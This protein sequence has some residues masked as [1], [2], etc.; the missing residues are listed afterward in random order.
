MHSATC[1]AVVLTRLVCADGPDGYGV[2]TESARLAT[3][4]AFCDSLK[5][6]TL[7]AT[8][9][10]PAGGGGGGGGGGWGG[11]GGGGDGGAGGGGGRGGG[12]RTGAV[13]SGGQGTGRRTRLGTGR[14]EAPPPQAG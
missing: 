4:L 7:V 11:G 10:A 14:S 3:V 13:A 12:L 6:P 9:P 5:P 1:G 2:M 8:A